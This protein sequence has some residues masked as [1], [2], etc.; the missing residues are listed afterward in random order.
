LPREA[1]TESRSLAVEAR[2][3]IGGLHRLARLGALYPA[4]HPRFRETLAE[5][6]PRLEALCDPE[7]WL[8]IGFGDGGL[9][10]AGIEMDLGDPEARRLHELVSPLGIDEIAIEKSSGGADLHRLLRSL[11]ERSQRFAQGGAIR[12]E[13]LPE[14]LPAGVRVAWREEG[15]SVPIALSAHR[16]RELLREAAGRLR[17][18][19]ETGG[20]EARGA[21]ARDALVEVI[22]RASASAGPVPPALAGTAE[23]GL[24][25]VLELCTNALRENLGALLQRD[26]RPE[27]LRG[28]LRATEIAGALAADQESMGLLLDVLHEAWPDLG[29]K[30][31]VRDA[32]PAEIPE[33]DSVADPAHTCRELERVIAGTSS[34]RLD[35]VEQ[36]LEATS[37]ALHLLGS[38]R[39]SEEHRVAAAARLRAGLK[40]RVQPEVVSLLEEAL[41]DALARDAIAEIDR[42][43]P[44]VLEVLRESSALAP[45]KLLLGPVATSGGAALHEALWPHLVRWIACE[46]PCPDPRLAERAL[47][48][49]TTVPERERESCL[50]RAAERLADARLDGRCPLLRSAHR[51]LYPLFERLRA[52]DRSGSFAGALREMFA[53]SALPTPIAE[54]LQALPPTSPLADRLLGALLSEREEAPSAGLRSCAVQILTTLLER[55]PSSRRGEPWV[56]PAVE[57]LGSSEHPSTAA[58]LERIATERESLLRHAWPPEARRRAIRMRAAARRSG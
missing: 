45:W 26:F 17:E 5:W 44:P 22:E 37:I 54:A 6:R 56:G 34:L 9:R 15:H 31:A 16:L 50:E 11:A 35:E 1:A 38:A 3:L 7:G 51:A 41:R 49:A 10:L 28:A 42:V 14:D 32:A 30:S 4:E 57:A 33:Q 19:G 24:E 2:A 13:E 39:G 23:R 20:G 53:R 40:R 18:E 25:Q 12:A 55:L 52:K 21:R 36:S 58:L 27:E 29:Q 46:P 43:V 48:L 47:A 8:R